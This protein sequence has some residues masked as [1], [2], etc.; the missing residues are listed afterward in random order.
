MTSMPLVSCPDCGRDVSTLAGAC[1]HC[2]RPMPANALRSPQ[3][4]VT[5]QEETLWRGTPSP[6]VLI[7]RGAGLL[8]TLIVVVVAAHI[9]ASFTADLTTQSRIISAGWWI[10]AAVFVVQAIRLGMAVLVLRG[11]MYTITN[12]RIIIERGVL[13]KAVSEIDLRTID[14][15]QFFQ[16][17]MHRLLGIGDVTLVSTDRTMPT[18]VLRDAPDPRALREL[19]RSHAYRVSQRQLFTRQA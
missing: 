4:F 1:P 7:G 12:Q 14:D 6:K 9:F 19:I 3:A 13:S 11:T 15:T 17:P 8:L 18:L 16:S 5:A 2:G 10:A